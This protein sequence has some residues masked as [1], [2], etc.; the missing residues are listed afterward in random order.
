MIG[1]GLGYATAR[2]SAAVELR[3]VE[4][5]NERLRTEHG[6]EHLRHRQAVYHDFL[7]SAHRYHQAVGGVEPF[8]TPADYTAWRN[9]YEHD[10]SAV[11]LFGTEPAWRAGQALDK[12]MQDA[13]DALGDPDK[14]S[15]PLEDNFMK[16]WDEVVVAMRPDTAPT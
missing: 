6:E 9:K 5:E 15:G 13:L 3:K 11:S 10:L 8:P 4:A 2:R 1:S 7:D 12:A 14:Y 16:R